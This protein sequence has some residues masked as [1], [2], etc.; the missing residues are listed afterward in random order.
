MAKLSAPQSPERPKHPGRTGNDVHMPAVPVKAPL[1]DANHGTPMAG[2]GMIVQ[3]WGPLQPHAHRTEQA[4]SS[5]LPAQ[6]V[7]SGDSND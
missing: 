6:L 5:H 2:P 1:G 7:N 4:V 3:Q